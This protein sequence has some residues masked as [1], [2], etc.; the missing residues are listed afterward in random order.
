MLAQGKVRIND[1]ADSLNDIG[2]RFLRPSL[3]RPLGFRV[4]LVQG[5]A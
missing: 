1:I 2:V 5:V 3:L 4:R